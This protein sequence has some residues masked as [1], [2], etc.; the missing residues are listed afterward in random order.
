MAERGAGPGRPAGPA[1]AGPAP[2]PPEPGVRD[3]LE[4]L[5]VRRASVLTTA[6]SISDEKTNSRQMIIHMSIACASQF[7]IPTVGH[8][9]GNDTDDLLYDNRLRHLC[10]IFYYFVCVFLCFSFVV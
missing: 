10:I 5:R 1:E 6:Y 3:C 7:T 9:V 4:G 2:P 8:S